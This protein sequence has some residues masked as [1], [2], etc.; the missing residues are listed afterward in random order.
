MR[1]ALF[2]LLLAGFVP[3]AAAADAPADRLER[4]VI[5]MRHG[6]RSAMSSPE[7]LGEYSAR[8]WPHFA[9][10]PGHLTANGARLV[11]MLGGW[12]RD[13]YR[14]AGLLDEDDC[15]VYYWANR[16]QRTE[17]TAAALAAGLTPGCAAP[18]HRAPASPDPLFDA[19]LTPL[20]PPDGPRLL[21]A[22]RAQAGG[23]LHAWDARQ[24]PGRDRFE[25]L[26]LQCAATPCTDRERGRARRTLADTPVALGLDEQ[27]HL[28]V[29]S[30]ALQVAGIAESLLMAYADGLSFDGWRGIDAR[31]IGAALQVHG[32]GIALRTRT[33]EVG[34]QT[35]SYLAMRLLATL[36][37]GAGVP[38]LAD[39]IGADEKIIVLSGHDGTVTMLA[40]LLGL[41]WHLDGYG[42]GEAAP[43][44]GLIFELWRRSGD[45]GHYVRLRYVAQ[46]LDQMRYRQPL[47]RRS[48]PLSAILQPAYCAQ[49]CS[50]A[51]FAA[52]LMTRLAP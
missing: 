21:K 35:S 3:P 43:G 6:V 36:Q 9:V 24:R 7:A 50:L 46:G 37:R 27:G 10:P 42:P 40:G 2:A 30:P 5:V 52:G 44:G 26:L 47:T 23:D 25:A 49:D 18:V 8:P 33:P 39:P 34:R 45:D 28:R 13:R 14:T 31:T 20:A 19:P 38:V 48:P 12:Y 15:N 1:I 22:V 41:D 32:A 17:A 16:T 11:T 29:T 4:V 51:A